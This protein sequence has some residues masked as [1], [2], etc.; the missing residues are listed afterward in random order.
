M[1][2]E[3]I[4]ANEVLGSLYMAKN[5]W[6]TRGI[7]WHNLYKWSYFTLL[8]N[9]FF[10]AHLEDHPHDHLFQPWKKRPFGRGPNNSKWIELPRNF[11]PCLEYA[12]QKTVSSCET[13]CAILPIFCGIL[14][15]MFKKK[16]TVDASEML[17]NS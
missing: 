5:K 11:L 2:P 9:W 10:G 13:Q 15:E 7:S 6:V 8:I 3:P 14:N 12:T 4:V 16:H 1:G 17:L